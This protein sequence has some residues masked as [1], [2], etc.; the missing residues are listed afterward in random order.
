MIAYFTA[1]IIGKRYNLKNYE[2]IVSYLKQKGL[3]VISDHILKTTELEIKTEDKTARLS[4]Q[5]KLERWITSAH[6]VISETSYPSTSVGFEISYAVAHHKPVLLLYNH[7]STPP[8]LLAQYFD[9]KLICEKYTPTTLESTLDDFLH[10]ASHTA[11]TRF[12]FF[13][14]PHIAR[15]LETIAKQRKIPKSVYLRQLIET[16]MEKE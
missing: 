7:D 4:F 2:R 3:T 9:E 13:I 6:F 1:S 15:Y 10:Y 16:D 8:S 14:Q 12:T 11:D 5:K